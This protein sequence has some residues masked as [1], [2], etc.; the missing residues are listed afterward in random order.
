MAARLERAGV[1]DRRL[2]EALATVPRHRLI[3][4]ALRGRAYH[5]VSLPIGEGQ[6][7]SAPSVV[8]AMTQALALEG[9]ESVLEIGTGSGYQAAILSRLASRICSVERVPRLAARARTAL[10]QLRISN[11]VIHLGDGSRGRP[12]DAPFDA[13]VVTAG[14]PAVPQPLLDQLA[15]GGCLVGPFGSREEQ[16]LLC[17]RR[18]RRGRVEHQVLGRCRFVDLLGAHGWAA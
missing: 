14:G 9:P 17:V 13:I 11:V 6:T 10:D 5:D 2:L 16:R 8:A 1:T 18:T 12:Q 4:E 15:P 3:P 7:I